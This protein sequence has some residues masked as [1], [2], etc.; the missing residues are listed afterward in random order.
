MAFGRDGARESSFAACLA[1]SPVYGLTR[2]QAREIIGRQVDVIEKHW[3]EAADLA[4][5]TESQRNYLW[6]RQVLN[7]YAS[8]GCAQNGS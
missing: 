2:S 5:L 8:Y 1:A 4:R 6:H 3:T 7:P